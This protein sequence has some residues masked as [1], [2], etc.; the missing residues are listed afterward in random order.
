MQHLVRKYTRWMGYELIYIEVK[1]YYTL[2]IGDLY[3]LRGE[4]V[5]HCKYVE[6]YFH[7]EAVVFLNL[8]REGGRCQ[9]Y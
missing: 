6:I 3:D 7:S 8:F 4:G 2:A 1:I 5:H 9:K